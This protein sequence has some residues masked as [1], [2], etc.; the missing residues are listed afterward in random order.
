MKT[1]LKIVL[2]LL[3]CII[4]VG[5]VVVGVRYLDK[6]ANDDKKIE[7][8]VDDGL[9]Y[10]IV[11]MADEKEVAR[12]RYIDE[13]TVITIPDVP[14]KTGYTGTWADF[15]LNGGNKLVHAVYEPITYTI[16]YVNPSYATTHNEYYVF[17]ENSETRQGGKSSGSYP[18]T[19][20]VEDGD[21]YISELNSTFQCACGK[22]ATYAFEG[23]FEDAAKTIPF[24]GVIESGTTGDIV[25]YAYIFMQGTHFV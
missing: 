14:E 22:N 12:T 10:S 7:Q 23:W 6:P 9:G 19:Y 11:F 16:T 13:N 1:F 24:D 25:I 4:L 17:G 8:P 15:T 5:V 21:V 20:T 2:I 18:T 3:L